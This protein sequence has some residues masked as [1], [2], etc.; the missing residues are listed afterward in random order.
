MNCARRKRYIFNRL[1]ATDERKNLHKNPKEMVLLA[2]HP[3]RTFIIIIHQ[4]YMDIL[5]KFVLSVRNNNSNSIIKDR[6]VIKVT[7]LEDIIKDF[8]RE[9]A[10]IVKRVSLTDFVSLVV[11]LIL[12]LLVL[13]PNNDCSKY[14]LSIALHR[15]YELKMAFFR[16]CFYH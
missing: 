16:F 13:S 15:D 10:L 3:K 2:L 6:A 8:I 4:N 7:F 12:L 1:L 11:F 14:Q 9:H 5:S